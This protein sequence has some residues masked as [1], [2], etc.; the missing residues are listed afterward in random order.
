VSRALLGL[1]ALCAVAL[2]EARSPAVTR[3]A[4]VQVGESAPA[5]LLNTL[6]GNA[7][8][9]DFNGRP[10]YINVFATWCP[11]CRGE[12]PSI[13]AQTKQYGDRIVFLFVDEQESPAIVQGFARKFGVLAP[14]AVDRGQ[15]AATFAVGGLPESIFIDRHGVVRYIYRGLIPENVLDEELSKLAST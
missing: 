6:D 4:V 2:A 14:V 7:M 8:T 5:F 3:G 1:A 10:A 13:V 12:L 9:G 15:F 11:P